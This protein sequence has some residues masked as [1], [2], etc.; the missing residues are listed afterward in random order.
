MVQKPQI[1]KNSNLI[2]S[3]S[4]YIIPMA[5]TRQQFELESCSNQNCKWASF[6]THR[7][8]PSERNKCTSRKKKIDMIYMS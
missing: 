1:G 7:C 4:G 6:L 5:I 8:H 3:D 2:D